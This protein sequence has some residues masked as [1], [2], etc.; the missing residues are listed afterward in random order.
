L[1]ILCAFPV[2]TLAGLVLAFLVLLPA[3]AGAFS[4][5]AGAAALPVLLTAS[6]RLPFPVA[7]LGHDSFL[8]RATQRGWE[9]TEGSRVGVR[10]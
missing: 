5:L 9:G 3:P 8:S 7:L 2:L 4:G 6:A 10:N 1:L